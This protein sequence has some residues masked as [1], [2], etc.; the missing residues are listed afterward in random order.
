MK[1]EF[2]LFLKNTRSKL[3]ITQQEAV[4]IL[5]NSESK[6]S[7]L[8]L[9]TYSRWERGTTKP[10]LSKQIVIAR[11]LGQDVASLI[12]Q[13]TK[14]PS[15][16]KKDFELSIQRNHNPYNYQKTDFTTKHYNSLTNQLDLCHNLMAFHNDYL[17][18]D[19]SLSDFQKANLK[20]DIFFDKHGEMI[21]HLLYGFLD[22]STLTSGHASKKLSNCEFIQ[23]QTHNDKS[24]TLYVISGFSLLSSPRKA[25]ISKT[26]DIIRQ[27]KKIKFLE[28]NCHNQEAYSIHERNPE[29]EFLFKGPS[30]A[31]GG[32]KVFGNNYRYIRLK[33]SAE[34]VLAYKV[35]SS[36]VPFTHEHIK[37]N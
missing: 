4:N 12:D 19:T 2:S 24:L 13:K 32:I 10:I 14:V 9:T 1:K 31:F 30:T 29:C 8:D 25:I 26:L 33:L 35:V 27:N 3:Q 15:K 6:L 18:L 36:L 17:G 28:T 20:L 21:G 23:P 34:S 11:A 22:T 5:I 7:R 37:N 16:E